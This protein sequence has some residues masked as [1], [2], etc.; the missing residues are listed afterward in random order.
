[1]YLIKVI[2][3]FTVLASWSMV[4]DGFD[5]D[6]YD[7]TPGN[8]STDDGEAEGTQRRSLDDQSLNGITGPG[9]RQESIYKMK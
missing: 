7:S 1:M 2:P 8:V 9:V 3:K 4:N 5:E 6:W